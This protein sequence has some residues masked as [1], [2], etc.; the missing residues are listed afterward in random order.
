MV[1]IPITMCHGIRHDGDYPLTSDHLE[2]LVKIAAELNFESIDYNQLFQ[3]FREGGKLPPRPIM[4]DFDH[5]VKS[6]R[7]EIH[8]VL[9][10]YGYAGN[11]FINTGPVNE[12]YANP[13]PPFSLREIMTSCGTR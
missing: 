11:L 9:S 1:R 5:P 2:R 12:L 4:F 3:W 10:K 13:I 7:Y 8:E 6:M